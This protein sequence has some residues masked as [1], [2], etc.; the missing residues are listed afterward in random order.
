MALDVSQLNAPRQKI[1]MKEQECCYGLF[2]A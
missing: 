1:M 2:S